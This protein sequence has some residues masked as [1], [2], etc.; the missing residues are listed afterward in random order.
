[1]KSFYG[2]VLALGML[3]HVPVPAQAAG[4]FPIPN[5]AVRVLVGLAPGGP[6]D[7]Q[8]R[9]VALHLQK[10]LGVPVVVENRPGASMMMAA[11]EVARAPADGHTL[12]YSPSSPFAQ[13]PHT[14]EKLSYDPLK[15]F[16]PVSLGGLGPLVLVVHKSIPVESLQQL[17]AYAKAHPGALNYSSFGIGTSSHLFGQMLS[18]Q[19]GL[20]M[21]HVPYKGAGDVQKDLVA[22]RVHVMFAAAGGAVQFVRSG[23]VRMLGVAAPKRTALLPGVPTLSEQGGQGLD[24]DGWLGFFGPANL[25]PATVSRLN[26]ALAK[27]LAV[28]QVK[29]EFAKGAYEAASS[30]PSEFAALVR[31]SYQQWGKI[32]A[33]LGMRKE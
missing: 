5:K 30:T 29:E 23:Q 9:V 8:A 7:I 20:D 28:P 19:Y 31:Q 25:A 32:V 3:L 13:I 18:R 24:I 2:A 27:V 17:V 11:T 22:G 1:M 6:T 21:T 16:T 14:L 26:T 15:D 10:E 33:A 12:L 4:E